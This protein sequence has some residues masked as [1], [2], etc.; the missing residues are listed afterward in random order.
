M[1][2]CVCVCVCMCVY[3]HTHTHTYIYTYIYSFQVY[4][5]PLQMETRIPLSSSE[6]GHHRPEI[7]L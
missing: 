6:E 1:C 2:V 5:D 7:N 3:I 4:G